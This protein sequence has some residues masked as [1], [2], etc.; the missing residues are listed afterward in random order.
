MT[1]FLYPFLFRMCS[2]I[3]WLSI[4]LTIALQNVPP[5]FLEG[6]G[7]GSQLLF[8]FTYFKV[9]ISHD[10]AISKFQSWHL[11][12]RLY[13]SI[14]RRPKLWRRGLKRTIHLLIWMQGWRRNISTS[15]QG[16]KY[17]QDQPNKTNISNIS[18][19]IAGSINVL[20]VSSCME[21][22]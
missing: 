8:D 19:L 18:C 10:F 20:R 13:V 4:S 1:T 14:S 16:V 17:R 12:L 6:R 5:L 11:G 3:P 21:F 2:T 9:A 22:P 15:S 7:E